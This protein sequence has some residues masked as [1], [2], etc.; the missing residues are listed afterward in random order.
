MNDHHDIR[1]SQ[2]LH[3]LREVLGN[4][5]VGL[6]RASTDAGHRSYWRTTGLQPSRIVMDAPPGLE[7]VGRWL[8]IGDRLAAAGVRVP[9][10]L[11]RNLAGGFLLLEDLGGPTLAQSL[12]NETADAGMQAAFGQLITLQQMPVPADLP[13]FDEALLLR[14]AELFEQWFVQRHLGL[15]LDC[16]DVE[17]LQL[18]LRRLMDNAL[19]QAQVPVHRDFMLRNLMPVADGPAVL[20]FQDLVVGPVAYDIASLMRDAFLSWPEARVADWVGQYHARALAAGIPVPKDL[21]T[22]A[23]DVDFIGVQRHLKI[24]GIFC[25][26]H[27][28]DGKSRYI[29]D[30]TRFVTYLDN[31]LPRHAALAPLAEL[32]G[33]TLKPALAV[34]GAVA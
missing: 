4:P 6:E 29:A 19:S 31:V 2:R 27:Y 10:V 24:L 34:R 15:Q 9:Q 7:D 28:R 12:T 30:L 20:D 23:R 26:L 13:R 22:F 17:T 5:L 32:F 1:A 25:R 11:A 18:G 33:R 21:A 16:G 8:A 3:W 14:D